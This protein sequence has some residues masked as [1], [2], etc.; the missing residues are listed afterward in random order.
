MIDGVTFSGG[1]PPPPPQQPVVIITEAPAPAP[2]PPVPDVIYAPPVMIPLPQILIVNAPG[3][4]DYGRRGRQRPPQNPSQTNT[5]PANTNYVVVDEPPSTPAPVSTVPP[6]PGRTTA[7]APKVPLP[8][9]GAPPKREHPPIIGTR[10]P[11]KDKADS[12]PAERVPR[13]EGSTAPK[14]SCP[15]RAHNPFPH[16]KRN[17]ATTANRGF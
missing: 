16:A 10:E 4:P 14:E 17:S 13:G 11:A 15:A 12:T 1:G 8:E 6:L 7:N 2:P 9:A 3:N 5:Q